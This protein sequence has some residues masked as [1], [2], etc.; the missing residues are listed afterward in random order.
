MDYTIKNLRQTPDQAQAAGLSETLEA[1]FPREELGCETVGLSFQRIHPGKRQGFAHRHKLT[2]EVYVILS[3]SGRMLCGE[4]VL[5]VGPLDAI[6]VSPATVRAFEA[7]PEG[8]ELLVFG[9]HCAGDGEMLQG[10]EWPAG[11]G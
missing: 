7:G 11:A 2:E 6:R 1:H 9:P 3:G 5:A 8:L 4:E 10:H